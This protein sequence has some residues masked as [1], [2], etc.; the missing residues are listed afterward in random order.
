MV[1]CSWRY[2]RFQFHLFDINEGR[3]TAIRRTRA[4]Y[5]HWIVVRTERRTVDRSVDPVNRSDRPIIVDVVVNDNIVVIAVI[6]VDNNIVVIVV[7]IVDDNVSRS[8]IIMVVGR[9][10]LHNDVAV[11]SH[12]VWW[13]AVAV[14]LSAAVV[15]CAQAPQQ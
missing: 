13:V 11:S 3:R 7:I 2:W 8:T 1:A 9:T 5:C 15:C 4:N 6:I 10:R 14:A 12:V